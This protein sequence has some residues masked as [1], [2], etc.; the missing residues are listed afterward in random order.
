MRRGQ[1]G[2]DRLGMEVEGGR[3][4]VGEDRPGAEP[5]DRAGG[6]PE[7]ERRGQH[8]HARPDTEPAER[9]EQRVRAGC[10]ADRVRHAAVLRHRRLEALDVRPEH[11][12]LAREYVR[13][14]RPHVGAD[15]PVLRDE[16][17]KRDLHAA[18][19]KATAP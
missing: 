1:R 6:R 8:G 3:I 18:A 19:V 7:A 4:D 2:L 11:E 15:L 14:R 10:D 12:R 5:H 9:E 17:E 16:V 13:Q